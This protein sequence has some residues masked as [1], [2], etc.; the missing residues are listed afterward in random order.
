[1]SE[2]TAPG[3]QKKSILP[4]ILVIIALLGLSG[5][6][7]MRTFSRVVYK[8]FND[9]QKKVSMDVRFD[10]PS[11]YSGGSAD[12]YAY[13]P[14]SDEEVAEPY[15][16]AAERSRIR[17]AV[18]EEA[19]PPSPAQQRADVEVNDVISTAQDRFSTFAIDVDTG[20][21]TNSRRALRDGYLPDAST[22]R[23]EE[24]VNYFSYGYP[25]PD[26]DAFT[27][28][29]EGAPSPFS[30]EPN[31]Y[32]LRIGVQ[33]RRIANADRKPTHITFLVDVS[34]SMS[35]PDRIGMAKSAMRTLTQNMRPQDS[36]A[37]VT[38]AGSHRVVLP[39]TPGSASGKK[40]ILAAINELTTGGGTS[41]GSGM[42]LAYKEAAKN[43]KGGHISRVIVM[44]DGDANI[45]PTSMQ[46][47]LDKIKAHVEDGI[48]MT[49]LGFGNGNYNDYMME[50]L[51]N[52]GNGNYYYIDSEQ[53][54]QKLFGERLAGMLEV[55]A[56]DVKIQV[57]FNPGMVKSYRLI[58]Y[59]NR[60]IADQDFR[61]DRVDAGEIG[62]GHTVTALYELTTVANLSE[63]MAY[64]R[65]RHK[66]P[67]GHQASEQSF[68]LRPVDIKAK[69]KDSSADLQFAA[70]VAMFAE[71]LR[72]SKY[73]ANISYDLI[74]EIARAA[75]SPNQTD[76]A[77]LIELVTRAKDLHD[78]M[79][80]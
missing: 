79:W 71:K 40:K 55:I 59:E 10:G 44:S 60:A 28:S 31:T 46:E 73:A 6:F 32:L 69:L 76:R 2:P 49:T 25:S 17:A 14:P 80:R 52:K 13:A 34:G 15:G 12:N 5:V 37:I 65:I 51:A 33:G 53:E 72:G 42:E 39:D 27:V 9:A 78:K 29:M 4:T 24:F 43:A 22:V 8:K 56:K 35:G 41:M 48:T 70:A 19:E 47:I 54:V 38:Y 77:E 7:M 45:G 20:A 23:V 61:N 63:D 67:D 26:K 74:E 18:K 75:S 36:V 3:P 66:Q 57:E 62:A 11:D 64:V 68:T 58:G 1:M 50:Q 21:Y 16:A 30:T